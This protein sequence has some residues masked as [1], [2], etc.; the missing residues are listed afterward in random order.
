VPDVPATPAAPAKT[1]PVRPVDLDR[2]NIDGDGAA[3][4]DDHG[5][6]PGLGHAALALSS[7]VPAKR[8]PTA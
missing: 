3:V 5:A 4:T 2:G 1:V 6:P 8:G 7:T